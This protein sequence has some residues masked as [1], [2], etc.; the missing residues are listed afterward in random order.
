MPP[1]DYSASPSWLQWVV[2]ALAI[3]A[4]LAGIYG[5]SRKLWPV[6]RKFVRTIESLD[7]L[8]QFMVT[9]AATLH[10]QDKKIDEI[11]HEVQFNNGSSVKDAVTRVEEGVKGLYDRLDEVDIDRR[12]LREDLEQT[13]P[14][15]PA[16]KRPAKPN[17]E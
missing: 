7:D 17:K 1:I 3:M 6:L 16:R 10:D 12:E 5:F 2:G 9:T 8:P 11:H 13:K 15:S 4:L 14:H